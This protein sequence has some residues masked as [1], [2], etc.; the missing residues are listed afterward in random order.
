[1]P[2][3]HTDKCAIFT[4]L[5]AM[6]PVM[7]SQSDAQQMALPWCSSQSQSHAS[8]THSPSFPLAQAQ[9]R[10]ILSSNGRVERG[11]QP[12]AALQGCDPANSAT[13]SSHRFQPISRQKVSLGRESPSY[14]ALLRRARGL[15]WDG[16]PFPS[17]CCQ[18]TESA[19]PTMKKCCI[20]EASSCAMACLHGGSNNGDALMSPTQHKCARASVYRLRVLH[21]SYSDVLIPLPALDL[22]AGVS[23]FDPLGCPLAP[24]ARK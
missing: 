1:M 18:Q 8:L 9:S 6:M 20:R 4:A 15:F 13:E 14:R 7:T 23:F 17:S 5:G 22:S 19:L 21:I 12:I 11:S 3:L 16:Q 24:R 10:K 2:R